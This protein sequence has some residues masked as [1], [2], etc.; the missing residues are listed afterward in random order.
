LAPG[1]YEIAAL[2]AGG[3]IAFVDAALNGHITCGYALLR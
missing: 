1:G 2:A 3:A